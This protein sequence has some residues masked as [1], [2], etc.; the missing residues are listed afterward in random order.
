M[1]VLVRNVS[2]FG[3]LTLPGLG[4][5]AHGAELEVSDEVA[6][7]ETSE[8][9]P[10]TDSDPHWLTRPTEDG[11]VEAYTPGTGLLGGI[12]FVRVVKAAEKTKQPPAP[13]VSSDEK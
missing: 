11:G 10:A 9:R 6:G 5:V 4:V 1:S 13:A 8:W 3:D 12:H 2:P 7:V